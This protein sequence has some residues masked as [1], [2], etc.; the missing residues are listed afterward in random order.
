EVVIWPTGRKIGP[1]ESEHAAPA[2]R[3]HLVDLT[4]R[5]LPNVEV[6]L[7]DLDDGTSTAP[8]DLEQRYASR[9]QVWHVVADE[10]VT[11]AQVGR[12]GIPTQWTDGAALWSRSRFVIL[13]P[14]GSTPA[15]AD[16]P[17][18]HL[19]VAADGHVPTAELR[20]RV[21]HGQPIDQLV[22]PEVAGYIRR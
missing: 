4:F 8:A 2:H 19:L 22:S 10:F 6:D 14:T 7:S 16:L 21:Y 11:G 20:A 15:A 5:Q 12:C 9:G 18:H 3:A 1:D 17:P 13:H